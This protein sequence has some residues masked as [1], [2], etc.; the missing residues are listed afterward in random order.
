MIHAVLAIEQHWLYNMLALCCLSSIELKC[1]SCGS[2]EVRW[3]AGAADTSSS[4]FVLSSHFLKQSASSVRRRSC[5]S[6]AQLLS[7]VL[8]D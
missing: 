1:G 5:L 2:L 3:S 4:L 7:S 8:S 6:T